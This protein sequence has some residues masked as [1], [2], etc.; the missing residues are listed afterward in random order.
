VIDFLT[1][2]E[3]PNLGRWQDTPV[4]GQDL[5]SLRAN[6]QRGLA[7]P[8]PATN[9]RVRRTRSGPFALL[10]LVLLQLFREILNVGFQCGN[11]RVCRSPVSP[12]RERRAHLL[13]M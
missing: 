2:Q 8:H 10:R 13:L 11:R 6:P 1:I 7:D 3:R 9:V 12:S 4:G 5:G